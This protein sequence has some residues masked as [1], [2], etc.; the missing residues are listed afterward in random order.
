MSED[1]KEIE[2][3]DKI[4]KFVKEILNFNKEIKKQ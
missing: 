2:N 4:L 1:E 3:P